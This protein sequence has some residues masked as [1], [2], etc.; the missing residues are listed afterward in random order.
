MIDFADDTKQKLKIFVQIK[1]VPDI[2]TSETLVYHNNA[3]M[4]RQVK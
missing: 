1:G 2:K 3:E 4:V